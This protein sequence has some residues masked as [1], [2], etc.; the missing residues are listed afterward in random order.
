MAEIEEG[1]KQAENHVRG[2]C[3]GAHHNA[4]LISS[5]TQKFVSQNHR[6]SETLQGLERRLFEYLLAQDNMNEHSATPNGLLTPSDQSLPKIEEND[7][8]KE[9]EMYD[10][11]VDRNE[12]F[13]GPTPIETTETHR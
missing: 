3:E 7:D 1:L 6:N 2:L 10:L 11:P 12:S 4:D 5:L 9:R 8:C 13:A